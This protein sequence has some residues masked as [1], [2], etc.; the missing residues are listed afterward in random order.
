MTSGNENIN[1]D[2]EVRSLHHGIGV[3]R[4]SGRGAPAHGYDPPRLCHLVVE[5][6]Y[7][8]GYLLC[9]C[10]GYYYHVGLSRRRAEYDSHAVEVV[11]AAP[12]RNHLYGAAGETEHHYE[13]GGGLSPLEDRVGYRVR[14]QELLYARD[15]RELRHALVGVFL[16]RHT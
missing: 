16:Y 9:H 12:G 7:G 14:L 6:F 8:R 4:P 3:I 2:D 15:G 10:A 13:H 1:R 5:R 11:A